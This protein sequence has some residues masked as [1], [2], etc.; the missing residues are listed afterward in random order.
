MAITHEGNGWARGIFEHHATHTAY[1]YLLHWAEG[2]PIVWKASVSREGKPC[3]NV[4]GAAYDVDAAADIPTVLAAQH[5][6]PAI[7][8]DCC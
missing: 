1:A 5:V 3:G 6:E 4:V 8:R 2:S 7:E